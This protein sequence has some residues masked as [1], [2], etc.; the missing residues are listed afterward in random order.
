MAGERHAMCESAFKGWTSSL[1]DRILF[2]ETWGVIR[3]FDTSYWGTDLAPGLN[4]L[5]EKIGQAPV[6]LVTLLM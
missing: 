4:V 2:C 5:R 6:Q 3:N 1:F